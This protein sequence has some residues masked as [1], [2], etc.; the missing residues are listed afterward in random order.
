[1]DEEARG[2]PRLGGVGSD[3]LGGQLVAELLR[4]VALHCENSAVARAVT[5]DAI[6]VD[7]RGGSACRRRGSRPPY[8]RPKGVPYTVVAPFS[9]AS[10][11]ASISRASATSNAVSPPV[12]VVYVCIVSIAPP[13][14]RCET[15]EC[16][17]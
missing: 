14:Q 16:A 6:A 1:V 2:A 8:A 10:H 12:L 5:V 4:V 17:M 13:E 7:A 9:S 11:A 3:Q 15:A